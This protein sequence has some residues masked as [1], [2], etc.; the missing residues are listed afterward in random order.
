[1]TTP[2]LLSTLAPIPFALLAACSSGPRPEETAAK[3]KLASDLVQCQNERSQFKQDLQAAQAEL[4]RAKEASAPPVN[5]LGTVALQ[6]GASGG[7]GAP[8]VNL[9]PAQMSGVQKVIVSN[10]ATLVD[11]YEKALKRNPN[12]R[13][14][15]HVTARFTLKNTG[16]AGTVVFAP[17]IDAEMEKCM[18]GKFQRWKFPTFSSGEALIELPVNLLAK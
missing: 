11:C 3:A 17:H 2:R 5:Q 18:A 10:G 4:K 16:S 1:M 8:D 7:G 13:T 9:T 15:D 12:L 14:V 6:A